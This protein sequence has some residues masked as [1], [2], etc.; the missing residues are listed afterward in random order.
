MAKDNILVLDD[1]V[2]ILN[3]LER[4]LKDEYKV[5]TS[6]N[7]K[8]ALELLQKHHFSLVLADQ[9]MPGM[10]GVEFLEES[11]KIHEI[12]SSPEFKSRKLSFELKPDKN[13]LLSQSISPTPLPLNF[14]VFNNSPLSASQ[15][16]NIP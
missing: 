3:A 7:G 10:T 13:L 2:E 15:N 9:R 5:Y 4:Q 6:S 8:E 14:N 16:C 11:I 1:Q 12:N